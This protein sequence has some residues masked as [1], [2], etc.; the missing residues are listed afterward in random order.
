MLE[1]QAVCTLLIPFILLETIV[2]KS[3]FTPLTTQQASKSETKILSQGNMSL[4]EK[5]ENYRRWQ[6]NVS[7]ITFLSGSGC[8]VLLQN[9]GRGSEEV[10]AINLTSISWNGQPWGCGGGGD[11]FISSFLQAAIH[12]QTGSQTKTLW[13]NSKGEGQGTP[14][15]AIMY[16]QYA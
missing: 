1:I 5:P 13:F 3:M 9:R 2:T 6:T 7:K 16:K 4:F 15:Q 8:Q 10:K 12:R 11:V 14:R